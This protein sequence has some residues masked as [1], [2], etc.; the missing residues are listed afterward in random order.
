MLEKWKFCLLK[1]LVFSLSHWKDISKDYSSP[2]SWLAPC[3]AIGRAAVIV[4]LPPGPLTI[5]HDPYIASYKPGWGIFPADSVSWLGLGM[6]FWQ[7]LSHQASSLLTAQ[8]IMHENPTISTALWG[9]LG[10]FSALTPAGLSLFFS[11]FGFGSAPQN[12]AW[13]KLAQ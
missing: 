8:G 13:S 11:F 4:P 10:F 1:M 3:R 9:G 7:A 6:F 12:L 5:Q 2:W